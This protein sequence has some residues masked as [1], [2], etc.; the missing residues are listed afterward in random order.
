[1]LVFGAWSGMDASVVEAGLPTPWL[2]VRER[3]FWYTY[4]LWFGVLAC[5]LLSERDETSV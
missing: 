1:M 4:H 2:R 5:P 3:I